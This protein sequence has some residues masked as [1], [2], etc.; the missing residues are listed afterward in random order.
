MGD[1]RYTPLVEAM[2]RQLKPCVGDL[3]WR[4]AALLLRHFETR[5]CQV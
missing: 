5:Q 3:H 2:E 1:P 4:Q